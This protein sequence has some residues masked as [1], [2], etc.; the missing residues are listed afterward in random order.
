MLD[1]TPPV[2]TKGFQNPLWE[3]GEEDV[4]CRRGEYAFGRWLLLYALK[5]EY[6]KIRKHYTKQF[7]DFWVMPHWTVDVKSR[8]AG[9][10]EFLVPQSCLTNC[11]FY[12][13]V[14]EDDLMGWLSMEEVLAL[15]IDFDLP[16]EPGRRCLY[17]DMHSMDELLEIFRGERKWKK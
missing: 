11:D 8:Q 9:A 5:F 16:Y 17:K 3:R 14:C 6:W 15:P 10:S 2:R 4:I 1:E 13:A 7:W 12:V